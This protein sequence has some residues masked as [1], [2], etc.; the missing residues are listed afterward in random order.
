[1]SNESSSHSTKPRPFW[2][3]FRAHYYLARRLKRLSPRQA[4]GSAFEAARKRNYV[5]VV[6]KPSEV[7]VRIDVDGSVWELTD[8]EKRYVDTEFSPFDGAKPYIKSDYRE[9]TALG[10]ING[11]IDRAKVPEGIPIN[12]VSSPS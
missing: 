2:Q 5:R 1:M 10:A 11:F 4:F 7:L 12:P 3:R 8:A 6:P 9:R